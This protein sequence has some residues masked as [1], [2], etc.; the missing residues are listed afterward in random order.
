MWK[1]ANSGNTRRQSF[2]TFDKTYP[3]EAH[4]AKSARDKSPPRGIQLH[5]GS[6]LLR[7]RAS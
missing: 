3:A 6:S 5:L 2:G 7:S 1:K 4:G